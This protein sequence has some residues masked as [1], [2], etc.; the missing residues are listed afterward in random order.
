MLNGGDKVGS[1]ELSDDGEKIVLVEMRRN[2]FQARVI[3]VTR[4]VGQATGA[5]LPVR[6][7]NFIEEIKYGRF[8][9]AEE[10]L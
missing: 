8:H 10:G 5:I 3:F 6:F 7:Q 1:V 9:H 2:C 4:M